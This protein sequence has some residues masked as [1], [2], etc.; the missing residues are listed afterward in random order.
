MFDNNLIFN[1]IKNFNKN[2]FFNKM[3]IR[4]ND[5][6]IRELIKY[7]LLSNEKKS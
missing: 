5:I 7:S 1:F 6:E 3:Q 4:I 2:K